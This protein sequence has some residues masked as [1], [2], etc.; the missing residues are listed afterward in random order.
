MSLQMLY[1]PSLQWLHFRQEY[2]GSMAIRSPLY[3]FRTFF[4]QLKIQLH[5]D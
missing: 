1:D 2:P 4:P 3:K 5:H